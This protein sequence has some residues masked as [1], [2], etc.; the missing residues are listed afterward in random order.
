M[1]E[2][3]RSVGAARCCR[4]GQCPHQCRTSQGPAW[5]LGSMIRWIGWSA[6]FGTG[7]VLYRRQ[8]QWGNIEDRSTDRGVKSVF[9][10]CGWCADCGCGWWGGTHA[11]IAGF[12]RGTPASL[13]LCRSHSNEA[14]WSLGR[15]MLRVRTLQRTEDDDDGIRRQSGGYR[16]CL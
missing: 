10:D 5:P 11:P 9:A 6:G 16:R 7:F 12:G 15:S 13:L 8:R 2:S 1:L 3:P 4:A 14:P